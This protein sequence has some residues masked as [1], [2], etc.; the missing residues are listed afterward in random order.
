MAKRIPISDINEIPTH[1]KTTQYTSFDEMPAVLSI[2]DVCNIFKC[3]ELTVK[4]LVKRGELKASRISN[5]LYFLK[6]S[7]WALM[8]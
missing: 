3:S 8:N 2:E 4:N 7:V 1:N 5:K 6:E